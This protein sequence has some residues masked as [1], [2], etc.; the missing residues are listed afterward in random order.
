[1]D[2][3]GDGFGGVV[4]LKMQFKNPIDNWDDVGFKLRTYENIGGNGGNTALVDKLE[5]DVLVPL[6]RCDSPCN[7]CWEDGT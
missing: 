6:L 2:T 5:R 7:T 1:L 4:T 3:S